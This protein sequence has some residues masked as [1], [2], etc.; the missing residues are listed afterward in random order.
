MTGRERMRAAMAGGTPDR[1]PVMCQLALGHYF[2]NAGLDAI[3]VWHDT[4]AFAEALVTL[5]R[6]YGFDGILVNLPGRDPDWRDAIRSVERE[7]DAAGTR[8]IRWCDGRVTVAPPDE[9][10]WVTTDGGDATRPAFDE[11]DPERLFYVEPHDLSGPNYPFSWGIADE[12]API[13]ADRFF[14]PWHTDTLKRV[15]MRAPDVSLHAEVFSPFS[16]LMELCDHESVLMA[17]ALDP[18]RVDAAL[19]RLAEGAARLAVLW[20]GTDCDAVL[21]SSAFVGGGLISRDDYA[22]FELPHLS[23]IVRAVSGVR[24]DLPVYVHTCGVLGDRLDLVAESGVSGI[25]TLDPPPLGDVQLADAFRQV[26]DRMFL[27]GNLDPVGTL[28][29]GSV[30]DVRDAARERLSIARG[31]AGYVLS[32]ACSVPSHAPPENVMALRSVVDEWDG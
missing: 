3:D 6:R 21:V 17:L 1:V 11:V 9:T 24:P 32:T 25:D 23:R 15:R 20:A 4:A 27:K 29:Q 18:D 16:Q 13:D 8:R 30:D 5:Q 22:R 10:P 28:L 14:P 26:G 12:P 19:D 31:R 7:P 2:L